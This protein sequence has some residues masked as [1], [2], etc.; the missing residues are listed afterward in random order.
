MRGCSGFARTE[1]VKNK[2]FQQNVSNILPHVFFSSTSPV[3]MNFVTEFKAHRS[4]HFYGF[5]IVH[6]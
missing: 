1:C 2:P 5:Q 6:D 3:S 4:T